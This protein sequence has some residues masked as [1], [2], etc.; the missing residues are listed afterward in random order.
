MAMRRLAGCILVTS[1]PLM[2]IEPA[3]TSSSPAIMR[4]IVDLPQPDGPEQRAELALADRQVDIAD[5]GEVA[6]ALADRAHFDVL[7]VLA[8]V[9]RRPIWRLNVHASASQT[10]IEPF[11]RLFQR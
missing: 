1:A 10:I 2:K 3:V 6:V 5:R 11:S 7:Q 9:R 4:S 8:P